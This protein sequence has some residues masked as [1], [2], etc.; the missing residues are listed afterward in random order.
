MRGVAFQMRF[1]RLALVLMCAQGAPALHA[2]LGSAA[3]VPL[4]E[5]ALVNVAVNVANESSMPAVAEPPQLSE[6]FTRVLSHVRAELTNVTRDV[7]TVE[8]APPASDPD[9]SARAALREIPALGAVRR[10]AG[11]PPGARRRGGDS[12][13]RLRAGLRRREDLL[14]RSGP[15]RLP[16]EGPG[17]LCHHHTLFHN[18]FFG[19][20]FQE[21]N[22]LSF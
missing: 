10:G 17:P 15:H 9:G 19:E 8:A 2:T 7:E 18:L 11:G 4:D 6:P 3:L 21:K 14:G 20:G 1:A 22:L 16:P 13:L 12:R 5:P